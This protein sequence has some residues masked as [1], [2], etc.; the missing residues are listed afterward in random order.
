[1][2]KFQINWALFVFELPEQ[3]QIERSKLQKL[4]NGRLCHPNYSRP[5]ANPKEKEF[6]SELQQ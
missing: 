2:Q 5:K 4:E 6:L 1:M 3:D